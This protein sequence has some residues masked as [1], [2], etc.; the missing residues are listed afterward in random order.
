[1]PAIDYR[2]WAGPVTSSPESSDITV[3]Y[4]VG[5]HAKAKRSNYNDYEVANEMI[6]LRLGQAIGLPIPSGVTLELDGERYFSSLIG[7]A[8]G[9]PLPPGD[10]RLAAELDP[11][12]TC[13]TVVFDSWICNADRHDGNFHFDDEDAQLYLIDHGNALFG[14]NGISR[15]KEHEE[16]I[17]IE[18][19]MHLLLREMRSLSPFDEWED[20]ILQLP[21]YLIRDA[22][23]S[24][25]RECVN[26]QE[27]QCCFEFLVK[28]RSRLREIFARSQD[29]TS[30]FPR[31]EST[32]FRVVENNDSEPEY[33]I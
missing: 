1:M 18:P 20:R 8:T 15:L 24:V 4:D 9:E 17:C 32:L 30:L 3:L 11:H 25:D 13:G 33:Y 5:L 2:I 10:A 19:G 14:A 6:S 28:R 12:T 31:L 23:Y 27:M 21:T 7:A 16:S 29:N 22:V 26:R